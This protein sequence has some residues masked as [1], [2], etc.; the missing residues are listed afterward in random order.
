[1]EGIDP[2]IACHRLHVGPLVRPKAAKMLHSK[3]QKVRGTKQKSTKDALQQVHLRSLVP[4]VGCKPRS[5]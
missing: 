2:K 5:R 3:S 1:M 4:R